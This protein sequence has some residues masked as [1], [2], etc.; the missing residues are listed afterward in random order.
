MLVALK[1]ITIYFVL[2][3][4]KALFRALLLFL[5]FFFYCRVQTLRGFICYIFFMSQ[6][7]EKL[8]FDFSVMKHARIKGGSCFPLD[9]N[10]FYL[11]RAILTFAFYNI[12]CYNEVYEVE[13]R[14]L[15]GRLKVM[16]EAVSPF[17]F[18]RVPISSG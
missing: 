8:S 18:Q 15:K 13:K 5:F 4:R 6:L 7:D 14:S 12:Y 9:Q 10:R 16:G 3:V 2:L 11:R 1:S 17:L